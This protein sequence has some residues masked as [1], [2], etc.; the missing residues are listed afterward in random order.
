M[1][2]MIMCKWSQYRV[3]W[4]CL[5]NED[6]NIIIL[7]SACSLVEEIHFVIKLIIAII[8]V[9]GESQVLYRCTC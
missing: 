8:I 3:L 2:I 9:A 5:F 1:Y 6:F 4:G 7:L